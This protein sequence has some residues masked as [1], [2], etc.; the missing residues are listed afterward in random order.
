MR[1]SEKETACK[2]GSSISRKSAKSK[3]VNFLNVLSHED[4]ACSAISIA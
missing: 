2:N 4:L 3:R 1:L